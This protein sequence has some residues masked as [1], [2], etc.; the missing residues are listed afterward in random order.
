ML[1]SLTIILAGTDTVQFI[2]LA[3]LSCSLTFSRFFK[4]VSTIQFFLLA[5]ALNPEIQAKAHAQLDLVIGQDRLPIFGD[6]PQ[7]PY[8]EAIIM[9]SLR[10]HPSLPLGRKSVYSL[11]CFSVLTHR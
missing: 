8:I 4:T 9:E 6:R 11:Y 10:W 5:M 7:L 3:I 2:I 1:Y